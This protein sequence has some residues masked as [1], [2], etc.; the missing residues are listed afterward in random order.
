M[1]TARN[2]ALFLP[3]GETEEKDLSWFSGT[4]AADISADGKAVLLREAGEAGGPGGAAY[5]R[6]VDGSPAVK[7]T[8]G[9]AE[10]LSRDAKWAACIRESPPRILLVPT[11]A[12]ESRSLVNEGFEE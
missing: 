3:A 7:V 5:L 10:A 8:E 9:T 1:G 4:D 6:R 12:G 2:E 11:G